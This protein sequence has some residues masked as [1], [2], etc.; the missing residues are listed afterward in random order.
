M[1]E[2]SWDSLAMP[3]MSAHISS[4]ASMEKGS[5]ICTP[6]SSMPKSRMAFRQLMGTTAQR[7]MLRSS[8]YS[9]IGTVSSQ[10]SRKRAV[11]RVYTR[12]MGVV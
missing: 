11:C 6:S 3:C 5:S 2:P 7:L 4:R 12:G 8:W 10:M 1:A 9:D